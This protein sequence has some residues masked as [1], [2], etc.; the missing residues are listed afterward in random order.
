VSP[1]AER[2][3]SSSAE[4]ERG[5]SASAASGGEF[6]RLVVEKLPQKLRPA[7]WYA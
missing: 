3:T 5:S 2:G 7:G 4:R 1:S 6:Y